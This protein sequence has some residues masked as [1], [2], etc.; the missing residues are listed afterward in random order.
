MVS[1]F[2]RSTATLTVLFSLSAAAQSQPNPPDV[3][4]VNQR[5]ERVMFYTDLV[6]GKVAIVNTFF[7]TCST[8]C[9]IMGASFSKLER[10]LQQLDRPDIVLISISVDPL[11][12]TPGRLK[13]FADAHHAGSG[14]TLLTGSKPDVDRV[15]ASLDFSV[16][17]KL[18]HSSGLRALDDES[19][20][21]TWIGGSAKVA[22]TKWLAWSPEKLASEILSFAPGA[23]RQRA[24][25]GTGN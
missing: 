5:G 10:R 8:V 21:R 11:N 14:W 4:L 3:P 7:T 25:K 17:D 2:F 22:N 13:E 12:D 24:G 1:L 6:K 9:P 19:G 23:G 15:L 18:S 20:L 16:T